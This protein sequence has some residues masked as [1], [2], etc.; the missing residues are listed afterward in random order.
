MFSKWGIQY[1]V[2]KS[3]WFLGGLSSFPSF[4]Q[5]SVFYTCVCLRCGLS[6]VS[7][8]YISVS[9]LIGILGILWTG[10]DV[11]DHLSQSF[12][13]AD[14]GTGLDGKW[15]VQGHTEWGCNPGVFCLKDWS[16]VVPRIREEMCSPVRT[17]HFGERE[18][19]A[20]QFVGTD[21]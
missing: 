18:A 2:F 5:M 4:Q 3:C 13:F 1:W 19:G 10:R 7:R 16:E 11:G 6:A 8:T 12:H 15:L 20:A 14:E 9:H 17:F 21:T